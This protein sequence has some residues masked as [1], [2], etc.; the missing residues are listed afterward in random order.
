MDLGDEDDTAY[1]SADY[2]GGD[3]DGGRAKGGGAG[4]VSEARRLW[5]LEE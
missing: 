4:G 5:E 3:A 1:G 2:W